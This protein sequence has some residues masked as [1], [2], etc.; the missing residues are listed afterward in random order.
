MDGSDRVLQESPR[1]EPELCPG[2]KSAGPAHQLAELKLMDSAH[3]T[4]LVAVTDIFFYTKVRDALLPQ[5]RLEKARSQADIAEKAVAA[6]PVAVILDMND[7]LLDAFEAL[8]TL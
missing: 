2:K 1:S 3:N 8:T 5:Y 6:N 4:V 7:Q